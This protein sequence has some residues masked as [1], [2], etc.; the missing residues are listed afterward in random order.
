MLLIL[1]CVDNL[2]IGGERLANIN[3]IKELLSHRFEMKD[4]KELH[5][6]LGIKVI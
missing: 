3:H 2:V 6:F 4:M 1:L 5:Y